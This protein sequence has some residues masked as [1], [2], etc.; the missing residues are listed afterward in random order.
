MKKLIDIGEIPQEHIKDGLLVRF[1][2]DTDI[3]NEIAFADIN[4]GQGLYEYPEDKRKVIAVY[5]KI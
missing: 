1:D 2:K 5:K 4:E 3:N